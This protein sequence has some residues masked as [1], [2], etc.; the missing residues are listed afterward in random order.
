M[1][2]AYANGWRYTTVTGA[3][4]KKRFQQTF[5]SADQTHVVMAWIY[6]PWMP[7]LQLH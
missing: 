4:I 7:Y 3:S 2:W 6:R 5:S 1:V